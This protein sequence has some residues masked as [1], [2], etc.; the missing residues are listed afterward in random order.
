MKYHLNGVH[1]SEVHKFPA[2]SPTETT[3]AKKSTDP[4]DT[5]HLLIILPQLSG[6]ITYFDVCTSSVAE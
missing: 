6:V 2:K 1:V 5:T 4:F 3:H